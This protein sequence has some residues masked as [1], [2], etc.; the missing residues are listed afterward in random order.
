MSPPRY[1]VRELART[2]P[3]APIPGPEI[4]S[5]PRRGASGFYLS[6]HRRRRTASP[7]SVL[8]ARCGSWCKLRCALKSWRRR[9]SQWRAAPPVGLPRSQRKD[10]H[11]PTANGTG[12]G[13]P[14]GGYFHIHARRPGR[15]RC[16]A[17]RSRTQWRHTRLGSRLIRVFSGVYS[18]FHLQCVFGVL[19]ES[20]E[21]GK[22]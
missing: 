4:T 16:S 8:P 14:L 5:H 17:A 3:P 21:G 6:D 18:W 1:L 9:S 22:W 2:S 12:T 15:S 19:W 10:H 20:G 7:H 11:S 13:Q